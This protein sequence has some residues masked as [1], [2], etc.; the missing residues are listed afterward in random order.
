MRTGKSY[1]SRVRA[2][3]IVAN[4]WLCFQ[5]N[6]THNTEPGTYHFNQLFNRS[7]QLMLREMRALDFFDGS[8]RIYN[9]NTFLVFTAYSKPADNSIVRQMSEW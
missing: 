9:V 1:G 5:G 3:N 2:E 8:F 4:A 6:L 7:Q